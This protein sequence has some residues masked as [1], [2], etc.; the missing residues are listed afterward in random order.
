MK[1]ILNSAA[2]A[3]YGMHNWTTSLVVITDEEILKQM[4]KIAPI[5]MPK[6]N[7]ALRKILNV[8]KDKIIRAVLP[9]GE[10]KTPCKPS[11]NV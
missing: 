1:T 11:P 4:A 9:I 8:P 5:K 10:P 7:K 3:P 6:I 2:S